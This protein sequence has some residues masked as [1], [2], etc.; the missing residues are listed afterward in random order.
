MKESK[1]PEGCKDNSVNSSDGSFSL[2]NKPQSIPPE[3][4]KEAIAKKLSFNRG[5]YS[6]PLATDEADTDLLETEYKAE[7]GQED[8]EKNPSEK[9]YASKSKA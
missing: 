5:A 6:G 7:H 4:C 3:D 2:P 8:A 9:D 1:L